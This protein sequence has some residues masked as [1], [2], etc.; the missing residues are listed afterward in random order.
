MKILSAFV[1]LFLIASPAWSSH[2]EDVA[3]RH[4]GAVSRQWGERID[5]VIT[6]FVARG[7]EVALTLDAC[8]GPG[9]SGYDEALILWLRQEKI[10]A[11]LFVTARW[12]RANEA[13]F[14]ELAG[15]KNFEIANHGLNHRP[16]AVTPRS[17]YGISATGSVAETLKEILGG[18]ATLE[19]LGAAPPEFF[20]PG[21][22]WL[23]DVALRIAKDLGQETAGYSIAGDQG[24]TLPASA[25]TRAVL[26]ARPGDILLLHFNQPKSGTREGLTAAIKE[27][28]RRGTTFVKL[29]DVVK[30]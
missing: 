15:D 29:S 13:I 16:C 30:R 18:S 1:A 7:N 19:A 23:D 8:G 12:A 6:S 9:G 26:K 27:L 10:P 20:R 2:M 28:Q 25:V 5:G 21:T 4:E 24:A 17:V 11:T 22:A 3:R 14:R